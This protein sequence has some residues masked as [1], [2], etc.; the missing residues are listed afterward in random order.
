MSLINKDLVL[1]EGS[2]AVKV[3]GIRASQTITF[4]NNSLDGGESIEVNGVAIVEGVDFN[5]QSNDAATAQDFADAVTASNDPNIKGK[6]RVKSVVGGVV[7]LEAI[8]AGTAGN[9]YTLAETDGATD[10]ITLGGATFENGIFCQGVYQAEEAGE[11]F[12]APLEDGLEFNPARELL[13]RNVRTSTTESEPSR[14][15]IKSSTGSLPIELKAGSTEGALPEWDALMLAL[16]GA[17]RRSVNEITTEA[18]NTSTVLNIAA[19]DVGKI[20][21]GDTIKI[22]KIGLL[23]QDHISP[24]KSVDNIAETVTLLI[25]ATDLDGNVVA[26]PDN[27]VIAPFV[28]YY[29]KSNEAPTLSVTNYIGGEIREKVTGVRPTALDINNFS[30]GQISDMT[31]GLEGIDLKKEVGQPLYNPSFDKS[32]PPVILDAKVYQDDSE[33][34]VNNF[35]MNFA[36]TVAFKTATG[37]KTGRIASRITDFALTGSI[38]PY[39]EADNVDRFDTFELNKGFSLFARTFNPDEVSPLDTKKEVI[40]FYSPNCRMTEFSTGDQEG[41][42]TDAINF[43]AHRVEGNDTVFLTVI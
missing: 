15:G 35:A 25:P 42:A 31:F 40:A 10:D 34:L 3:E 7:T 6:I 30:T 23:T 24:V 39:T 14:V 19:A 32:V 36:N 41:L 38:D 11:D 13:E 21:V 2:V 28:T 4:S 18:G 12:I 8:D 1:N 26:V 43:S 37:S 33:I 9:A 29:V 27:A 16:L 22:K 20:Q 5:D 17:R